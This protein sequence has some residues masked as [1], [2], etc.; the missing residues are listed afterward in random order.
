[1]LDSGVIPLGRK[2]PFARRLA[3]LHDAFEK[4]LLD[5]RPASAA[6]EAPFHGASARAA[7]QLAH[8]RGVILAALGSAG[9]EVTEYSPATVKK[10]VTGHGRADKAQ[11][12]HMVGRLLPGMPEDVRP[13][14]LSDAL[15]VALCHL[16][17]HAHASA[18]RAAARR[19][20]P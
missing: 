12:D 14:D 10:A 18:V 6:V 11:V 7:L 15:A 5:L 3:T 19:S 13:H 20:A 1:V 9:V 8:A 2:A 17:H 16:I 4:L